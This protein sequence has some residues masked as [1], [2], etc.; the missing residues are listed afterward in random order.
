MLESIEHARYSSKSF[1]YLDRQGLTFTNEI[2]LIKHSNWQHFE[3]LN[4]QFVALNP[5]APAHDDSNPMAKCEEELNPLVPEVTLKNGQRSIVVLVY[6]M[7]ATLRSTA[8]LNR[9][10]MT[11]RL[12]RRISRRQVN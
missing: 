1:V 11:T 8:W 2:L 7:F 9:I 6:N 12:N 10:S 3:T 5:F 4:I